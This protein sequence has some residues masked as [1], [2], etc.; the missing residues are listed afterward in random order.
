MP[1]VV[2]PQLPN[3]AAPPRPGLE[4]NARK[5]AE[6]ASGLL[7]AAGGPAVRSHLNRLIGGA[8]NLPRV[9]ML[10]EPGAAAAE[11][12][13]AMT[14]LLHMPAP[15]MRVKTLAEPVG[16][17]LRDLSAEAVSTARALGLP[18]SMDVIRS[19]PLQ[20]ALRERAKIQR[21]LQNDVGLLGEEGVPIKEIYEAIEQRILSFR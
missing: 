6:I 15:F 13:D 1:P 20:D 19:L 2:M 4:A 12:S 7:M 16:P 8:P 21:L 3:T 17:L 11:G 10:F 9:P 5:A 14:L 18:H